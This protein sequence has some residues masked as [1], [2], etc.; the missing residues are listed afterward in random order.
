MYFQAK[1]ASILESLPHTESVIYNQCQADASSTVVAQAKCLVKLFRSSE[2]IQRYR[3]DYR[4]S[5]DE[6]MPGLRP[7][8]KIV[9]GMKETA[10]DLLTLKSNIT[11]EK[12]LAPETPEN[13]PSDIESSKTKSFSVKEKLSLLK[14]DKSITNLGNPRA[15]SKTTEEFDSHISKHIQ[16]NYNIFRHLSYIKKK[17]FRMAEKEVDNDVANS[18]MAVKNDLKKIAIR[19]KRKMSMTGIVQNISAFQ[20]K[21]SV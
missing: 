1:A 16:K 10:Q 12:P 14:K 8:S 20:V 15:N 13:K 17:A 6:I 11:A 4:K 7:L 5:S 19:M 21:T 3:Y 2:Q 18:K 9:H